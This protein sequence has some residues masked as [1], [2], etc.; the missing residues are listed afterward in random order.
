MVLHKPYGNSDKPSHSSLRVKGKIP[1]YPGCII[2]A[3]KFSEKQAS[4]ATIKEGL[5]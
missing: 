4:R 3:G 2:L 1:F 5:V